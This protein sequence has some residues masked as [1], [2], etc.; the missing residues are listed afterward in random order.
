MASAI[1]MVLCRL[2]RVLCQLT[3]WAQLRARNMPPAAP[4]LRSSQHPSMLSLVR[5]IIRILIL[6]HHISIL[7]LR[8]LLL[9]VLL[10][11][12][13]AARQDT[14]LQPVTTSRGQE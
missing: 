4:L 13:T 11:A 10:R 14:L 7:L 9:R 3:L 8:L 5:L 12:I 1:V 2:V 6:L